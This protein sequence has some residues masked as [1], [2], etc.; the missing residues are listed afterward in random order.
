MTQSVHIHERLE[1]GVGWEKEQRQDSYPIPSNKPLLSF[2]AWL[3][4]HLNC[5][6]QS[7]LPLTSK[8]VAS[9]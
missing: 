2:N 9:L 4:Y 6:Y 8:I 3:K 5:F 7:L 1:F